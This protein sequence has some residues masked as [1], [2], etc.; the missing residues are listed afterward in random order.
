MTTL[1]RFHSYSLS[2]VAVN[3]L[4]ISEAIVDSAITMV[5]GL[6][7][8]LLSP[9]IRTNAI[10]SVPDSEFTESFQAYSNSYESSRMS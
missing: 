9:L 3:S 4:A 10:L 6:I 7:A 2:R 8:Y 1:T 5:F